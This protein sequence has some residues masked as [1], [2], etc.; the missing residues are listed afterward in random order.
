MTEVVIDQRSA[1]PADHVDP[2]WR[3]YQL[4]KR[5]R[6]ALDRRL[7]AARKTEADARGRL[8][9]VCQL[10]TLKA[11]RGEAAAATVLRAVR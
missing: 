5:A 9:R 2:V 1:T 7:S 10:L 3:E 6:R 8:V 11:G 4:A